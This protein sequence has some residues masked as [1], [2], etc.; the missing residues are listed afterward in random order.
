MSDGCTGSATSA[1]VYDREGVGLYRYDLVSSGGTIQATPNGVL[2]FDQSSF[3]TSASEFGQDGPPV[4]TA[5]ATA[6]YVH[7]FDAGSPRPCVVGVV[8][9]HLNADNTVTVNLA[10]VDGNRMTQI[11]D[12]IALPN[13]VIRTSKDDVHGAVLV[14][15]MSSEASLSKYLG[16]DPVGGI[17]ARSET[18][19]LLP[20]GLGVSPDGT[21][22]YVCQR[23]TCEAHPNQ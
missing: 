2:A 10:F 7:A 18:S 17:Q 19:T 22:F 1:F 16:V 3:A 4:V 8:A 20:T 12:P 6:W 5:G 11:G 21:Q 15:Y 9:P 23:E 14:G 13:Y